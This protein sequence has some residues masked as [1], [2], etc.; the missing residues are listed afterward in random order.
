MPAA[1]PAR[2]PQTRRSTWD[3]HRQTGAG[4]ARDRSDPDNGVVAERKHQAVVLLDDVVR[5]DGEVRAIK[6]THARRGRAATGTS[7]LDIYG[8]G[9]VVGVDRARPRRRRAPGSRAWHT[10][11]ATPASR[12]SK[13]R[14]DP[15]KR[16]RLNP[17]GNR[18]LNH[19]LHII[20]MA[21]IRHDSPGRVYYDRKIAEGKTKKEATARVETAHRR[22]RVPRPRRRRAPQLS[23]GPGRTIRGDSESSAAGLHPEHRHFGSVTARTHH[24]R[25][26]RTPAGRFDV[27]P[28]RPPTTLDTKRLRYRAEGAGGGVSPVGLVGCPF[29]LRSSWH[30]DM[31]RLRS[32]WHLGR[33]AVGARGVCAGGPASVVDDDCVV[34]V[35]AAGEEHPTATDAR[36]ISWPTS[37]LSSRRPRSCL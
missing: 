5:I 6:A 8:V 30:L 14:R 11:P 25:Y 32:L 19:A 20:A 12:R 27:A 23:S 18:Q 13:R 28:D 26:A 15:K 1:C 34:T 36:L 7:L 2:Q 31:R 37:Q 35:L 24:Q 21:Q 10:S 17:R 22:R 16:H 33:L 29:G 9:P 4:A 3:F